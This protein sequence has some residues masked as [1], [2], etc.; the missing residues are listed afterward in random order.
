MFGLRKKIRRWLYKR[1]I[2]HTIQV[3]LLIDKTMQV[4]GFDRP[5]RRALRII[6]KEIENNKEALIDLLNDVLTK[7]KE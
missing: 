5:A 3:L 7:I 2:K 6:R 4:K 1:R